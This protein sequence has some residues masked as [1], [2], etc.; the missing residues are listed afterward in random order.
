[1][2]NLLGEPVDRRGP[3]ETKER[4]PIHRRPPAFDELVPETEIFE[5][6]LKVID[7]LA[8][9]AK[10]GKIGFLADFL[11]G[12]F[13]GLESARSTLQRVRQLRR[14]QGDLF[15]ESGDR[16]FAQR[17]PFLFRCHDQGIDDPAAARV[18]TEVDVTIG[19]DC[20]EFKNACFAGAQKR[21]HRIV[22]DL[23]IKKIHA[24][25]FLSRPDRHGDQ[26]TP[27][28]QSGPLMPPSFRTRQKWTAI[29]SAAASDWLTSLM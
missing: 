8:P 14:E 17:G 25:Q 16:R 12:L 21:G 26:L 7:L 4:R 22:E 18:E 20:L 5:T 11:E 1:V 28:V 19:A 2:F 23:R 10:G 3:V 24:C 29:S 9:Y 27:Q 15:F 13:D 6:G